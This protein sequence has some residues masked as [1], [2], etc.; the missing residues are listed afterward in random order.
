MTFVDKRGY[1]SHR[2]RNSRQSRI[3]LLKN[4]G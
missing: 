1:T 2:I 4:L 3:L